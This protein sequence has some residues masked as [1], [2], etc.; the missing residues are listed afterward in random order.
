M[1]TPIT[2]EMLDNFKQ[3]LSVALGQGPSFSAP[4][5]PTFQNETKIKSV[6]LK[7]YVYEDGFGEKIGLTI[8]E[9]KNRTASHP[10]IAIHQ[11]NICGRRELFGQAGNPYLDYGLFLAE[12]GHRVFAIDLFLTGERQPEN[13]WDSRK[14]YETYP[15]WCV[16][17]KDITDIKGLVE[18]IYHH[19]NETESVNLIG[20]S[21]GGLVALFFAAVTSRVAGLVA[22]GAYF[23]KTQ[24]SDPWEHALYQSGFLN[25][26]KRE[27][28]I[29]QYMDLLLATVAKSTK[30]LLFVYQ[31]DTVIPNSVPSETE[32]SRL[33][34]FSQ[35]VQIYPLNLEHTFPKII[36]EQ[37]SQF[38]HQVQLSTPSSQIASIA[39]ELL[40][41][42][43]AK[44]LEYLLHEHRTL[45]AEKETQR[46]QAE[47]TYT[48]LEQRYFA[49][50]DQLEITRA[51]YQERVGIKGA[52]RELRRSIKQKLQGK[53]PETPSS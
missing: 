23:G 21:Q 52:L 40:F 41:E 3:Q 50:S 22:N 19:F 16:A 9:P 5:P 46:A 13:P 44:Q 49:L 37:G 31:R 2:P 35:N 17:G 51:A 29:A 43:A 4:A 45:L 12:Q 18:I 38:L 39:P 8:A 34:A 32:I 11:T 33:S 15:D 53:A 28:N 47:Q 27:A 1:T 48:D 26:Y 14:F 25:P 36:Q 20:H 42:D 6:I 24:Q 30:A 7:E 10:V